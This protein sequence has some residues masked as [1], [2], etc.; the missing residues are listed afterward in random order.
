LLSKFYTI[1]T[2][3]HSSTLTLYSTLTKA[4]ENVDMV[5]SGPYT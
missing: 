4:W 5:E 3:P 2:N 1:I